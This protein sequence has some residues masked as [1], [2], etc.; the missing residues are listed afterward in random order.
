MEESVHMLLYRVFHAKRNFLRISLEEMGLG[1]GQPKLIAYLAEHGPCHQQELANYFEVDPATVSR[2]IDSLK[3]GGF[4]TQVADESSRR[5]N[6]IDLTERGREAASQ[7]KARCRQLEDILLQG[8][9]AE[10]RKRFAG[11]LRRVYENL[12]NWK[13]RA[14]HGGF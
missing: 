7:W 2:M 13:G 10:E 1:A 11:D 9:D 3:K 6:R 12:H 5:R 8:F 14:E 4:I